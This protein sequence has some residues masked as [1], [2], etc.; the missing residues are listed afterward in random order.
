M[1]FK[2]INWMGKA[3]P[4]RIVKMP[5]VEGIDDDYLVCTLDFKD[6]LEDLDSP[7]LD[8]IMW[9]SRVLCYVYQDDIFLP[10]DQLIG[11][12]QEYLKEE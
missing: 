2:L 5:N 4:A 3:Y 1:N 9:K 7:A 8:A 12:V 6:A 11:V 10:D